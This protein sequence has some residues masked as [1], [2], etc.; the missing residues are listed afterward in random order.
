VTRRDLPFGRSTAMREDGELIRFPFEPVGSYAT[1]VLREMLRA[2]E[3][4]TD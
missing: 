1:E 4:Q 3:R 2:G